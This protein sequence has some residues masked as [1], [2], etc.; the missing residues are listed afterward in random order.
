M[1]ADT[2]L[3]FLNKIT[4]G[5][6]PGTKRFRYAYLSAFFNVLYYSSR[7]GD[8][9]ETSCSAYLVRIITKKNRE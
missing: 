9:Y 8:A 7:K 6:K 4:E 1:T 2:I 5:R 3:T